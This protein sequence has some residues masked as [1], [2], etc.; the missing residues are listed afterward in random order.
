[1]PQLTPNNRRNSDWPFGEGP[2]RDRRSSCASLGSCLDA[3]TAPVGAARRPRSEARAL[4]IAA[5]ALISLL[6]TDRDYAMVWDEGHTV[7]RERA[8]AD[9][10]ALVTRN[11]RGRAAAFTPSNL[12]AGWPFGREE[13][14]GHPPFYALLGLAGWWPS[15]SF[16]RPLTAYRLGPMVLASATIGI[17]YFHMTMC[18]GRLAGWTAAGSILLIPQVFSVPLRPLRH[19]DV[20]P[21]DPR[22]D[23]VPQRPASARWSVPFGV[24]LGLAA[25]TK[26]TGVFAAV[27]PLAWVAW[28]EW[29]S[30]IP[31]YP[32]MRSR[33]GRGPPRDAGP[34]DRA[35]RRRRHGV[36][37]PAAMVGRAAGGALAVRGLERDAIL[38]HTDPLALPGPFLSLRPALAQHDHPDRRLG[39]A[40]HP[41]LAWSASARRS[42]IARRR[43][44]AGSG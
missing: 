12:A 16:L 43:P 1:M 33:E 4:L 35:D 22:A 2:A 9:W 13:P 15:H 3:R 6:A 10:F 21:L 20:V 28:T 17:V 42:R 34:G 31:L 18:K 7:R 36:R 25:M 5:T 37:H 23:G 30:R 19:G 26:F 11:A 29:L 24:A 41:G 27:P 32:G 8:L 38:D 39:P 44:T 40:R 14:D